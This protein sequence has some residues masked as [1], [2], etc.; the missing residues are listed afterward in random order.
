MLVKTEPSHQYSVVFCCCARG[1]SRGHAD[2]MAS[3]MKVS[4]SKVCY[5]IPPCKNKNGAHR[6]LSTLSECLWRPSSGCENSEV[7]GWSFQQWWQQHEKQ[8][9]FWMATHFCHTTK[10]G[11][12]ENWDCLA[13]R[14]G[15]SG[16]TLSLPTTTYW[17]I[18]LHDFT[19]MYFSF[20]V[21]EILP[22]PYRFC[23]LMPVIY[24]VLS[25]NICNWRS[26][27]TFPL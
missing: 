2:K 22:F 15:G 12:W 14:R 18:Y 7:V 16:E 10:W 11:G 5:W 3:D 13:K 6:H 21:P 19:S 17:P 25:I 1:G 23:L 4:M 24:I 8:A 26:L 9:K 27:S 20:E